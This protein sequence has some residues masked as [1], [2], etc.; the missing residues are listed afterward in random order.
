MGRI[1]S[2]DKS[3][4]R[5][6]FQARAGKP[7]SSNALRSAG[8]DIET[9]AFRN[10]WWKSRNTGLMISFAPSGQGVMFFGVFSRKLRETNGNGGI[11]V[12]CCGRT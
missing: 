1:P 9:V 10:L 12:T 4:S 5:C 8:S 2:D 7:S 6:A 11:R 3:G